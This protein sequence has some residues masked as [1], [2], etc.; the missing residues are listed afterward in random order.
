MLAEKMRRQV[1]QDR[2]VGVGLK[3]IGVD[4]TENITARRPPS[5]L[6]MI[7]QEEYECGEPTIDREHQELFELSNSLIEAWLLPEW[8]SEAIDVLFESL[9]AHL[10]RHFADEEALLARH[11]YKDLDKHRL[12][13]IEL[14]EH[15][16][17]VAACAA[18]GKT[19]LGDMV[20][21]L[22]NTVVAQ[23]MFKA[24]QEFF[25]LF[26]KRESQALQR[27]LGNAISRNEL[28]LF[29]QPQARIGGE[30]FG[31]E[32][33]ARWGHQERGA[34]SPD[35]FIPLAEETGFIHQIGEWVLREAC[36]EAA[37]WPNPLTV[38]VN[39]SPVQ[40]HHNDLVGLVHE[41]L[42]QTGL[43]PHR[44]ELEI[45]EGVRLNN[46]SFVL[47]I[48]RRLKALGVRIAI[49]DFGSGYSSLAYL[50]S[51][52]F[53]KIKIDRSFIC[54][55]SRD[56][57]SVTVIRAVIG[58][59]RGLQIP[60]IAEGVET[61]EQLAFLKLESCDE[62]QGYLLGHPRP[63]A[64]YAAIIGRPTLEESNRRANVKSFHMLSRVE[65]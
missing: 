57:Q 45:T 43:A 8:S 27:D 42:L 15:A 65:R 44:L 47:T 61:E 39:L 63:I 52:P 5:V 16:R 14:L 50:Q 2:I 21:F 32:S 60:I 7:W 59:G 54:N 38:A 22:A 48:L 29:Y 51:F 40:F 64:D 62:I 49:D 26:R 37:S 3:L 11:G 18:A 34:I 28:S 13:H 35:V 25:H 4:V 10:A 31:F 30:I 33:L 9:L 17:E 58:L 55:L 53:D 23:H 46:K 20:D 36:R 56:S 12:A 19:T 6:R 24:D 41:V 1:A